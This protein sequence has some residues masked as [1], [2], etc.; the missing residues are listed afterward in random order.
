MGQILILKDLVL[1]TSNPPKVLPTMATVSP[2]LKLKFTL[3]RAG[4]KCGRYLVGRFS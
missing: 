4:G 3:S 1:G 2:G